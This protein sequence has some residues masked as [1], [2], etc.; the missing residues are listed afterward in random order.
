MQINSSASFLIKM[1]FVLLV[2]GV[3]LGSALGR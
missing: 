3:V 2:V 1:A